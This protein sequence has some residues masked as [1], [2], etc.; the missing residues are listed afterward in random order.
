MNG[1]HLDRHA[2]RIWLDAASDLF[3]DARGILT[4]AEFD[5]FLDVFVGLIG[6]H[7]ERQL[8][9]VQEERQS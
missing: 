9:G 2:L 1:E 5:V 8:T 7:Y 4:S 3:A 6:R